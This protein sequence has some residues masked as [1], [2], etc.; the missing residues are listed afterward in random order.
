MGKPGEFAGA[1]KSIL[2]QSLLNRAPTQSTL[3]Q[4]ATASTGAG[5]GRY[6]LGVWILVAVL[7]PL[8]GFLGARG[9]APEVGIAGLLCLP[10]VR[11]RRT[12][13]VA[14]ILF[15]VL[16]EWALISLFWSP[17]PAP[18]DLKGFTRFTGLHL[19]QQLLF[20]GALIVTAR[21]LSPELARKAMV[22]LGGG[23]LALIAVLT[24]EAL[25]QASLFRSLQPLIGKDVEASWALRSVAQGSYV[26][27]M[28]F[29][30][31]AVGIWAAGRRYLAAVF[32]G[33]GVLAL[34]L[35]HI[36]APVAA[37]ISSAAV[38]GLVIWLGRPAAIGGLVVAVLQ[39]LVAPWLIRG[40]AEDGM[41]RSLRPRLPA[42]WAARVDIWTFTS[43]R[44]TEK[45]LLGWGLDASRT[46]KGHIPLHPHDAAL[47]LWFELGAVGAL[48]G[49]L[50]WA[51]IFWRYATA[52]R[53][54][55][56]YAAT[57]CATAWSALVI[58]AVSFSL[59]QEW[60]VCLV[61]LAFAAVAVL[62][63]QLSGPALTQG[64]TR[65]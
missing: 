40:L 42:S 38:F 65:G 55:R 15:G 3:A 47:Q 12:D 17:A 11:V 30:P 53:T 60:W 13:T 59:W 44:M 39:T 29:W 6:L 62:S 64:A 41:F 33:G 25:S 27:A 57:G 51:F 19:F 23:L 22:W 35:L 45:P 56:L 5:S 7:T 24:A 34:A 50:I 1:E 49:A 26:L 52:A 36:A 8:S 9:F 37:L 18:H 63:R 58:G 10:L 21:T 28:L 20:S 46:F 54:R 43:A 2:S 31:V 48:L 4:S 14:L 16:V 32:I 61:A